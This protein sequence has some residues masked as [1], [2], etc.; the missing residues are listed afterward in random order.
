MMLITRKLGRKGSV[1]K[2]QKQ[3]RGGGA[4]KKMFLAG[5]TDSKVLRNRFKCNCREFGDVNEKRNRAN[6]RV[7]GYQKKRRKNG[8][9]QRGSMR[10]P[11]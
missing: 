5:K 10:D 7:W 9:S 2:K 8:F 1:N 6:D 4:K 3:Y 11:S